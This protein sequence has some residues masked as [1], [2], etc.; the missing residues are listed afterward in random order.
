MGGGVV[1]AE[2]VAGL[3]LAALML[4]WLVLDRVAKKRA[5]AR[6]ARFREHAAQALDLVAADDRNTRLT[7]NANGRGWY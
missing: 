3:T 6:A 4:L 1:N 5:R 2:Q 7:A